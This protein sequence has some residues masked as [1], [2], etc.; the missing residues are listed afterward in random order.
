MRMRTLLGKVTGVEKNLLLEHFVCGIELSDVPMEELQRIRL[1]I[2]TKRF[3]SVLKASLD[4]R[5]TRSFKRAN[6]NR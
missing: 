2:G 4:E 5:K 3:D 6:K 1:K